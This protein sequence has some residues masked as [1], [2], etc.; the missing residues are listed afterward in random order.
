MCICAAVHRDVHYV[1]AGALQ[2]QKR[3]LYLWELQRQAAVSTHWVLGTEHRSSE[4]AVS[5]PNY[6]SVYA[7]PLCSVLWP[8]LIGIP[9]LLT[10]SRHFHLIC[11][12]FSLK[13][14]WFSN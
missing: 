4:M 5:A 9:S 6:W 11:S 2:G 12:H 8:Q 10:E 1:P 14:S 7:A 13:T 3:A